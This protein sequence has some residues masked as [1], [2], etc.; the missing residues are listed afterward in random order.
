MNL[1]VSTSS[2]PLFKADAI[3]VLFFEDNQLFQQQLSS[4]ARKAPEVKAITEAGD[5]KGT[6]DLLPSRTQLNT[7]SQAASS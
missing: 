3:A 1:S 6:R 4:L 5:F 7:S 2:A